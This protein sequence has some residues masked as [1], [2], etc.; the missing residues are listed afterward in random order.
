MA[1][2]RKKKGIIFDM[3]GTLWDSSDQVAEVWSQV[4][5]EQYE[6][7]RPV[8]G[9]DLRRVMGKPMD[10]L[11]EALLGWLP[12]EKRP[13]LLQDCYEAENQ[14]LRAN[15]GRLYPDLEETLQRLQPDYHLYIVSN[16]QTGYIEAFL[17]HYHLG[18]FFDDTECYGNNELYKAENIRLVRDRNHL[19]EAVYVGD[20]Q[21]DHDASREAGVG[22]IHAAYG[23]GT[24][25]QQV[26]AVQEFAQLPAAADA[27]F[28]SIGDQIH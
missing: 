7:G 9:H 5:V 4:I 3:D 6:E 14:Y 28:K 11:A 17:E 26:P 25:R 22:F 15:G 19:D 24:I 16:C 21:G 12:V 8:T 10:Q 23:F 18:A 20:I 2:G 1:Q 27:F 13:S